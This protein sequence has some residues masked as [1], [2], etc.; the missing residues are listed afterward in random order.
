MSNAHKENCKVCKNKVTGNTEYCGEICQAADE[1]VET[2]EYLLSEADYNDLFVSEIEDMDDAS[3]AEAKAQILFAFKLLN[4]HKDSI[5]SVLVGHVDL[6][7]ASKI[8]DG[9]KQIKILD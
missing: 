5:N 3:E 7:A 4:K 1:L 9:L 6:G 2:Y 8:I